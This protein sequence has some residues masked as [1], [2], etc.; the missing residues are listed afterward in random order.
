[1]HILSGICPLMG[2]TGR[3]LLKM[4]NTLAD[5]GISQSL[6]AIALKLLLTMTLGYGVIPFDL[7]S[8]IKRNGVRTKYGFK[9]DYLRHSSPS[10]MQ[11]ST[12]GGCRS[13]P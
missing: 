12:N 3:V 4:R 7:G 6:D 11:D 10:K 5:L 2:T 8:S 1:M 9:D 13:Q